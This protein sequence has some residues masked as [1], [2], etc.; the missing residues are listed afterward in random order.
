M[1]IGGYPVYYGNPVE[2]VIYFKTLVDLNKANESE[3]SEC[4][5]VNPE[6]IFDIL[7]SRLVDEHGIITSKRKINPKQ[8]RKK[9][10]QKIK[11]QKIKPKQ[12]RQNKKPKPKKRPKKPKSKLKRKRELKRNQRLKRKNS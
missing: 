11:S 1:D 7:E 9:L 4:G 5:N 8:K 2:S 10:R 3:C 12:E 6:Q